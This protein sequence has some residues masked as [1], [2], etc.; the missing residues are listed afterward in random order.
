[1]TERPVSAN[2]TLHEELAE[3]LRR[4]NTDPNFVGDIDWADKEIEIKETAEHALVSK[5]ARIVEEVALK[6]V[7]TDHVETVSDKIRRQ[8]VEIERLGVGGKPIA[9]GGGRPAANACAP[10]TKGSSQRPC[11]VETASHTCL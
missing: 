2:V 7:G 11:V 6:K 10:T 3:V 9:T 8:Q 4:A 5:T 1:V